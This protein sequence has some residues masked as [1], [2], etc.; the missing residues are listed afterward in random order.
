MELELKHMIPYLPYGIKCEL[1]NY[2]SDYVGEQYGTC[3]GFYFLLGEAHY[4]F[5]DRETAGKDGSLVKPILKPLS[6]L[7][8][9]FSETTKQAILY[10]DECSRLPYN[11][12][13][14]LTKTLLY[15]DVVKLAKLHYD[16]F[17]L[18]RLGLAIDVTTMERTN[19]RF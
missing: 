8:D 7:T 2:K 10:L 6:N 1:L 12:N 14:M 15:S 19:G 16:I 5:K 4:T 3:N 13:D 17:G 9:E 11:D 18:I